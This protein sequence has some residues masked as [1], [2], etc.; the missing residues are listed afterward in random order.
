[1]YCISIIEPI[2]FYITVGKVFCLPAREYE[3][4]VVAQVYLVYT[5]RYWNINEIQLLLA[6]SIN[7]LT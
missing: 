1:M 7:S 6:I 5:D 2:Q 4:A 3:W